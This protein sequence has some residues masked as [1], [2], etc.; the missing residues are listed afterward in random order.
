MP[1][2]DV[3]QTAGRPAAVS[4]SPGRVPARRVPPPDFPAGAAVA[5]AAA[6]DASATLM[7]ASTDDEVARAVA[8]RQRPVA[9]DRKLGVG[10]DPDPV[11]SA[12][13]RF[14]IGRPGISRA[15]RTTEGPDGPQGERART[16]VGRRSPP[17]ARSRSPDR[18]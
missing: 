12:M 5:Y 1:T 9:L 17:R 14:L 2:T 4:P 10:R 11:L 18:G 7:A 16:P 3:E 13:E 8:G 6:V 15:A